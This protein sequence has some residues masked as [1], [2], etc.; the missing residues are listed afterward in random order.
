M[1]QNT[2]LKFRLLS[3]GIILSVVPVLLVTGISHLQ[4]QKL[5]NIANE[6]TDNLAMG[7]LQH[8]VESLYTTCHAQNQLLSDQIVSSINVAETVM[9]HIGKLT[10]A[11][12]HETWQTVN[13]YTKDKANVDI[14]KMMVGDTWFGKNSSMSEVSP[15]VDKVQDLVAGTCTVFQKI[16]D[17]DMLRVCTNVEKLDGT[18]AIGTY[19]PKINPDGKPNPVVETLLRGET[20]TGRAFV[21][22]KWYI[23]AYKPMFDDNRQVIGAL[24]VGVPQESVTSVRKAIMNTRIG[25]TGYVFVLDTKGEYV[26]SKNGKHDGENIMEMK[27]ENG[28]YFIKDICQKAQSLGESE[29]AE[30]R[31]LFT[32]PDTNATRLKIAKFTYYKPWDWIVVAAGYDDEIKEASH[33]M[34]DINTASTM[35]FAIVLVSC[36]VVSV[37]LWL[38]VA[39][40]LTRKISRV[41]SSLAAGAEQINTASCQ[42]S[43]GS[44]ILAEG[45]SEQASAIE[46]V[47]SS[48]EEISTTT[49]L[50]ADNAF[51]TE[52]LAKESYSSVNKGIDAMAR[53]KNAIDDIHRS[54]D[55]TA[56]IIKVIDE[57]AFQTNL[58]ALNAAVEAA[59]AGEA[60]KGFAVVAEEVRSLAI[61]SAEAARDTSQLIEDS[62]RNSNNGVNISGEVGAFLDEI[63]ANVAKTNGVIAEIS[64]SSTEQ[65]QSVKHINEAVMMVDR[66]TQQ[67]AANAE[68]SASASEELN[69]QA[70]TLNDLVDELYA[71]VNGSG[72]TK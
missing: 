57:I 45:A 35:L 46:E 47:S 40:G 61:R 72:T 4:S 64:S 52:A 67:N 68:E 1:L 63:N 28:D 7:D 14:P 27:D 36:V 12:E 65:A 71:M 6:E 22:N 25:D 9:D 34:S 11:T 43:S 51:Q 23:T 29:T 5:L 24:Y 13:Q 53:M 19:I 66:I 2:S 39:T 62:V 32:D 41:I 21:V 38:L 10:L 26:I 50:N 58:L 8:V 42:I 15:V 44:Q 31:Y 16:N 48:L 18:R 54:A 69:S 37:V 60:G 17:G 56:K 49:K 59:R 30:L 70:E 55:E 3:C 33:R 20:F